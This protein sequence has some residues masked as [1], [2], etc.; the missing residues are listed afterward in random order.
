LRFLF[1]IFY[2]LFF[3]FLFFLAIIM[4]KYIFCLLALSIC[5]TACKEDAEELSDFRVKQ[6]AILLTPG[7]RLA[8]V[9]TP[10]PETFNGVLFSYSSS[11]PSVVSV[12]AQGLVSALATGEAIITVST[13]SLSKNI[14]AKVVDEIVPVA[15]ITLTPTYVPDMNIGDSVQLSATALPAN[16]SLST[17]Y[18]FASKPSVLSVSETGMVKAIAAGTGEIGVR[19][20]LGDV[21]SKLTVKVKSLLTFPEIWL[22]DDASNLTKAANGNPLVFSGNIAAVAGPDAAN[23]AVGVPI[24]SYIRID[25]GITP[26]TGTTV[27]NYSIMMDIYL[28]SKGPWYSLL[29]T[30]LANS[31]DGQIWIDGSGRIGWAQSGGYSGSMPYN[32]W[33]RLVITVAAGNVKYY[34]NGTQ[35]YSGSHAT[36]FDLDPDGVLLFADPSGYDSDLAVAEV[37]LWNTT[38]DA[39]AVAELGAAVVTL[40]DRRIGVWLFD[41]PNALDKADK[42][43]TLTLIGNNTAIDGPSAT[44]KAVR[45]PLGSFI[46]VPHGMA[47][48]GAN[49]NGKVNNYTV[50]MDIMLPSQGDWYALFQTNIA[51]SSDCQ[52]WVDGSMRIGWA[53]TGGYSGYI[54]SG[55]WHR[56]LLAVD[57]VAVNYYLDGTLIYTGASSTNLALDLAGF[58]VG[59]D[60]NGYDADFYLAELAV[61]DFTFSADDAAKMGT[62]N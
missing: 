23:G 6:T 51:N 50:M 46:G 10:V 9:A 35:I 56:L 13:G 24:G 57:E 33:A 14:P 4:K 17:L 12:D 3:I 43:A 47:A 26:E 22:F 25:H 2:F 7:D 60:R 8:L 5:F 55:V 42:G 19:N 30:D 34:L 31:G 1:F 37:R 36:A 11:A 29:Q 15:S 38:L 45:I 32:A 41:D 53:G 62:V 40:S 61:W 54:S 27:R 21:V 48:N 59:A 20:A 18:W 44:N 39:A 16:A 52:V 49:N 28:P 58:L